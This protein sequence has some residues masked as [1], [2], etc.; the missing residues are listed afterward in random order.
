MAIRKIK[1]QKGY[2]EGVPCGNPAYTVFR[3]IPFGKPPVG[4]LRWKEPVDPEPWKG[5]RK[6]DTFPPLSIQ[7]KRTIGEFYQTEFFPMD[8]PMSEDCLYLNV[9]TPSTDGSEK[10]PVMMW[11]HGGAFLQGFGHEMEFDGEAFCRRGVI[12]VTINYRLGALGFFTHPELSRTSANKASGNYGILDQIHALK[13]I[14]S[15]I[16]AFGGD[17]ENVTI[18]GQ[19]AGGSSVQTLICSPLS[20]GLFHKAIIQSAVGINPSRDRYLLADAEQIGYD[21]CIKSGKT[22]EEL[23]ALPADELISVVDAALSLQKGGFPRLT[24]SPVVDGYVLQDSPGNIIS[25]GKHHDV[26]CMSGSVSGDKA[27]F[28]GWFEKSIVN[29]AKA[30]LNKGR[31]PLYLYHFNREMPGKDHPG[32][33]HSSELWYVFGTVHRCWRPMEAVDYKISMIMSDYWTNFAKNRDPNGDQL[34]LWT[35]YTLENPMILEIP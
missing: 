28:G 30:H 13:W 22:I 9:W 8:E 33:F 20:E 24:F 27:L 18:F 3:G 6:C 25:D 7:K 32:A 4:E 34:P 17:S 19:S 10:L 31:P 16:S 35:G 21:I 2:V 15:N 23:M 12:L 1:I 5:T 14:K 26:L 29:W 11:I